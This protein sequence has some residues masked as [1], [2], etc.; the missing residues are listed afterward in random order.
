MTIALTILWAVCVTIFL[1]RIP[2]GDL[3]EPVVVYLTM[4]LGVIGDISCI[5]A[6][7]GVMEL[8]EV[9]FAYLLMI[10]NVFLLGYG[11]AAYRWAFQSLRITAQ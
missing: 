3:L 6:R 10:P 4:P 11:V 1:S 2:S 8:N 5:F 7:R 9:L